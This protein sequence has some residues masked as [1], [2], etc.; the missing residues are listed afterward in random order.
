MRLLFVGDLHVGSTVAIADNAH[1]TTAE[2][3]WLRE[4]WQD[5]TKRARAKPYTLMLG[6]DL[7]DGPAHHGNL[8]TW[9]NHYEQRDA[10]IELLLPLV[11]KGQAV[12]AIRGT[13]AHVGDDG[14][15]DR[16]AAR[17]LGAKDLGHSAILDIGGTRLWWAH[18]GLSVGRLAWTETNS[19]AT[20]CR[21]AVYSPQP[22]RFIIAHHAHR[23]PVPVTVCG[24]T[25]AIT[26]CWQTQT[27]WAAGRWP[28][29]QTDIGALMLDTDAEQ[30]ERWIYAREKEITKIGNH[31]SP[32]RARRPAG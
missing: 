22:P 12:Y 30:I 7:I 15:D 9:G 31:H 2:Q 18:S 19:L 14:E 1:T 27:A 4:C 28:H 6:G 13:E 11:T 5:M 24:I 16:T 21:N 26:P 25:A 29:T 17:E 8:Q 10:A 23:A 3:G 20:A 32:K